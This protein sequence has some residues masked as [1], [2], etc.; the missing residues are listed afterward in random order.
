MSPTGNIFRHGVLFFLHTRLLSSIPALLLTAV[1]LLNSTVSAEACTPKI[2]WQADGNQP[3]FISAGSSV[4]FSWKVKND[5]SCDAVNYHLGFDT[6][7]P[8]SSSAD[9]GGEN[10]PAFTLLA[11]QTDFVEAKMVSAPS[12]SDEIGQTFKVYYDIFMHFPARLQHRQ[13]FKYDLP[14]RL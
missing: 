3:E 10:H 2:I 5:S 7:V 6:S 8:A 14:R 13:S 9:Y 11:G 1:F 12:N 4:T